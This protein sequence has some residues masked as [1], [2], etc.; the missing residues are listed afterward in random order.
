MA[1]KQFRN[2]SDL[3]NCIWPDSGDHNYRVLETFQTR[4]TVLAF[5]NYASEH[6]N[7][8]RTTTAIDLILWYL[9]LR[10]DSPQPLTQHSTGHLPSV[11]PNGQ[12]S[13]RS[14]QSSLR[15][16][17]H[18]VCASAQLPATPAPCLL[19]SLHPIFLYTCSEQPFYSFLNIESS[20]YTA[21]AKKSTF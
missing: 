11:L 13:P 7:N 4:H 18:P 9:L 17:G 8:L 1:K 3:H 19:P 5:F 6:E 16:Q 10:C 20:I 2:S 12:D 21:G 15:S 14:R